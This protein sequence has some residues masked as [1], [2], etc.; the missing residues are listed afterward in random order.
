LAGD[1]SYYC[2]DAYCYDPEGEAPAL[3]SG[4]HEAAVLADAHSQLL[5][6]DIPAAL[7]ALRHPVVL[8]RAPA[9]LVL[10]EGRP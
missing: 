3:R 8:V 2:E 9:G 5:T 1:W 10:A 4:V 7:G 6:N